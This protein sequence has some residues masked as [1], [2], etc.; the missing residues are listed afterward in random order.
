MSSYESWG[1]AEPLADEAP[2]GVDRPDAGEVAA[3]QQVAQEILSRTDETLARL[4]TSETTIND[5]LGV[6]ANNPA[7]GSWC[8]R[9]LDA[10]EQVALLLELREWV[11]WMSERYAVRGL[12]R[13]CWFQHG[14]VV[15]EL[16][17]L[18][19]S[20][21]ATFKEQPRTYSD[22]IVAFHDRW[23][24]PV[25]R[26][27]AERNWMQ[28]CAGNTHKPPSVEVPPTNQRE[29]DQYLGQVMTGVTPGQDAETVHA[30]IESGEATPLRDH[31]K[32]PTTP[33]FWRG[34]WWAILA[35]SPDGLWVPRPAHVAEKL[36]ALY[37]ELH[38]DERARHE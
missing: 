26:R 37:D 30:A 38:P 36:Q 25:M 12:I 15:E 23:F 11:D 28:G 13:P 32:D 31:L 16:T 10:Y 29:L 1:D 19:V 18:Y 7:G 35:N 6:L 22:D 33:V 14:P 24:W 5:I 34:S 8:W 27:V 17:G 2:A 3:I 21:R 4:E 20:W 9:Y